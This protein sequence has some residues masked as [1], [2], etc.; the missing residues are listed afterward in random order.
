[1]SRGQ[2]V[3]V[4]L[5]P[6]IGLAS[7]TTLVFVVLKLTHTVDWAWVWVLSPLWITVLGSLLL[8]AM[9]LTIAAIITSRETKWKKR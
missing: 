1:V 5:G 3:S 8:L 4:E 6:G 2:Q 9:L 7:L